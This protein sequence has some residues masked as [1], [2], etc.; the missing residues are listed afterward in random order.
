MTPSKIVSKPI[1]FRWQKSLIS[2][3]KKHYS[4]QSF[5]MSMKNFSNKIKFYV[6]RYKNFN[7]NILK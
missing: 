3:L 7:I 1:K 5:Y 6:K 2:Y 4:V